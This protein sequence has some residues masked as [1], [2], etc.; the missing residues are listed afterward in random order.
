MLTLSQSSTNDKFTS[1][2]EANMSAGHH[3]CVND[4]GENQLLDDD[5][6]HHDH[7]QE[8]QEDHKCPPT[9]RMLLMGFVSQK[10]LCVIYFWNP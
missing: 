8:D 7:H 6:R 9:Y 2:V 10:T 3:V 4:C 1:S 5:S